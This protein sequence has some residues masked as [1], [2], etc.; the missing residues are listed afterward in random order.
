[1][2]HQTGIRVLP[3]PPRPTSRR[4]PLL[5]LPYAGGGM[6]SYESWQRLLPQSV[7][8]QTLRL[9]GRETRIGEPLPSDL[10]G[11][12]CEIADEL[13]PHLNGPFAL[14]GHSLGALLAYEIAIRLR[15]A[16]RVEPRCLL[17]SGMRP[18]DRTH[19]AVRYSDMDGRTLRSAIEHMGGTDPEVLSNRELW[20]LYE[21]IIRSDLNLSDTYDHRSAEPLSCPVVAYGSKGDPELDQQSLEAW[22]SYT[23]GP[24]STRMFPGDHFYFQRWPEAFTMDLVN[25]LYQ[26]LLEA[27]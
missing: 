21:P 10:R 5:C 17:V 26:H 22:G 16:F 18:P 4:R 20:E 8:A 24:F 19:N 25:R 12:A 11:L 3:R 13:A 14:F 23:V 9:P 15:S 2:T 1:M 27:E 6:R 7:D